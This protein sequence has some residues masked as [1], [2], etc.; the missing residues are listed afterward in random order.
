M[1]KL[2]GGDAFCERLDQISE[3]VTKGGKL[4]VGWPENVTYNDGTQVGLIAAINE[5]GRPLPNGKI[6][7]PRPFMRLAIQEN[8]ASWAPQ[9]AAFLQANDYDTTAA[10]EAMGSE[11]VGQIVDSIDKLMDPALSPRTVAA[12]GFDKPLIGGLTKNSPG[13]LMRSSVTYEVTEG[14][15]RAPQGFFSRMLRGIK[16]FFG[17]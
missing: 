10:L 14:R 6:Q 8:S 16:N 4:S 3:G 13:G 15:A 1:A 17:G 12:K 9:I 11:I 5:Y 2:T 7:P